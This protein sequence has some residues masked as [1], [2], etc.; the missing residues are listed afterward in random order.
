VPSALSA[1]AHQSGLLRWILPFHVAGGS[2]R[3]KRARGAIAKIGPHTGRGIV[4]TIEDKVSRRGLRV[5]D[6]VHSRTFRRQSWVESA[7]TP[8]TL[9]W[10]AL[11][12]GRAG[13]ISSKTLD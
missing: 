11:Y 3:V 9:R 13:R 12:K 5:A 8:L 1:P 2:G 6:L 10:A 4:L 7:W